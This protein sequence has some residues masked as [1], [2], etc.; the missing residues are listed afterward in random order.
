VGKAPEEMTDPAEVIETAKEMAQKYAREGKPLPIYFG[1][2]DLGGGGEDDFLS[3]EELKAWADKRGA[4]VEQ[5][6]TEAV[7]A[8]HEECELHHYVSIRYSIVEE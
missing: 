3:D 1:D 2:A 6:R 7:E 4:E 8:A 5:A